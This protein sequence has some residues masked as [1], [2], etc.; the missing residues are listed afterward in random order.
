MPVSANLLAVLCCPA[1]KVAL[2]PLA[3]TALEQLNQKILAAEVSYA[4]GG[5]VIEALAEALITLDN[6]WIYTVA[7]NIPVMLAN[8]AISAAIL[9]VSVLDNSVADNPTL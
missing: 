6:Q 9:D 2:K 5:A 3:T 7:D 1:T 4:D 8:K